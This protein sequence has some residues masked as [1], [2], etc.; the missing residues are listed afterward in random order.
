MLAQQKNIDTIANNIAN[1]DTVGYT[2]NRVMFKDSLYTVMTNPEDPSSQ[3]NLLMGSGVL[4]GSTSKVY[5]EPIYTETEN[6]LDLS[7]HGEGYFAVEDENGEYKFT[8]DGGFKA[9]EVDGE[10]Y[11]VNA[12]GNFVLDD[13]MQR[14]TLE[15][16]VNDIKIYENGEIEGADT[17]I[18]VVGF[19]NPQGLISVGGNL[20]VQS[21]NSGEF[22]ML[23][24]PKIKQKMLEGS[25]VSVAEELTELIRAQRAYQV[26]SKAVTTADEME[27]L[28]NNLRA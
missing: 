6:A 17:K 15:G 8:R 16:N 11:L 27:S 3:E 28:A 23:E 22:Y 12:N 25:N 19:T 5:S 1:V 4:V 7:I 10:I 26:A 9:Q 20:S 14:I 2:K 13:T 21:E 24:E 18:G